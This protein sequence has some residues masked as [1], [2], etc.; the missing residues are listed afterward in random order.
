MSNGCK[1]RSTGEKR[2]EG[3]IFHIEAGVSMGPAEDNAM[4]SP[5]RPKALGG[6]IVVVNS[7]V[8]PVLDKCTSIFPAKCT[9]CNS[10]LLYF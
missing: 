6:A 3:G 9:N 10:K 2:D 7:F 4:R 1:G 8:V 5:G